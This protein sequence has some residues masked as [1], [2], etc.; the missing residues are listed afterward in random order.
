MEPLT[1]RLLVFLPSNLQVKFEFLG[2]FWKN[3]IKHDMFR[4]WIKIL[5][6]QFWSN[7]IASHAYTGQDQFGPRCLDAASS[8]CL[9]V[10]AREFKLICHLIFSTI[11]CAN[12]CT[13]F[14]ING[15]LFDWRLEIL[16]FQ[17][18]LWPQWLWLLHF[19]LLL[20]CSFVICKTDCP[21]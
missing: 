3:E 12:I 11:K 7:E 20:K 10:Y 19:V 13:M 2:Q 8:Y 9:P 17:C 21:L 16:W 15:L 14:N 18:S 4:S 1:H 6:F 5:N